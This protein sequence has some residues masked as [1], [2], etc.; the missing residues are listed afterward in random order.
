VADVLLVDDDSDVRFILGLVLGDAGHHV[1][2]AVDGI[3]AVAALEAAAPDVVVLDIM[4]PR[5]D[6]FGVLT[7]MRRRGL[8]P[9][10]RVLVLSCRTDPADLARGVALGVDEH[11]AKPFDPEHLAVLVARL[12]GAPAA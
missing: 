12:A 6:G 2:E 4:M 7:A 5:L 8:A 1:R 3:A 9:A 11:V 10:A